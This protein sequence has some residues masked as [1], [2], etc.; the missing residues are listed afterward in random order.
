MKKSLSLLS[1]AFALAL[2]YVLWLIGKFVNMP[3]GLNVPTILPPA[4]WGLMLAAV[5]LA[6]E[7]ATASGTPGAATRR[8]AFPRI[9]GNT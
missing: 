4:F 3:E 9:A 8:R 2:A 6:A 7:D 1:L 5:R